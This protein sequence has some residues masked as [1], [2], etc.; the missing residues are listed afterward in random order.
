MGVD[1]LIFW[2]LI[3]WRIWMSEQ[4]FKVPVVTNDYRFLF[5][6]CLQTDALLEILDFDDVPDS[7]NLCYYDL[8]QMVKSQNLL[9]EIVRG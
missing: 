3:F 7:F 6:F 1:V 5:M 9:N 2:L 4:L 8:E